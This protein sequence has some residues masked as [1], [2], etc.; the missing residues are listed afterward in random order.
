MNRPILRALGAALLAAG[1]AGCDSVT[2]IKL[3]ASIHACETNTATLC[4]TWQR[5]G[6][7]Y[8]ADWDQGSHAEIRVSKWE[9]DEVVFTRDDPTGTSAGMHAVYVGSPSGG[10]KVTNGI[11]TWM[12]DGETATGTWTAEW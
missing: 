10:R 8:V 9:D 1:L 11:V 12:R 6:T 3:P 5:V 2:G 4:S 7:I